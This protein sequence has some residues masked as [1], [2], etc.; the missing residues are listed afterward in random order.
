V[1]SAGASA[2]LVQVLIGEGKLDEAARRLADH[3]VDLSSDDYA[4]LRRK[5]VMG[6]INAGDLARADSALGADSTVDGL[7]LAGRLRLYHGDLAGAVRQLKAA[8]PFAGDRADAT[9]RT[10]LLALL[11]PIQADSLPEL[12]QALLA[13]AR[14]DT[15]RAIDGLEHVGAGLPPASGGAE[16]R[17]MGGRLAAASGKPAVAERLLAAAAAPEAPGT[18]PAAELALAELMLDLNRPQEAVAR[19][20]HLILSYPSS[21][22]VP[23]ARRRL[24]EA[25]GAVPKT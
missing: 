13:L 15:T 5:L 25:R 19:L 14:G 22:L 12:G 4:A 18:A 11:Q 6:Y 8:G 1:V 20:E 9:E 17:L 10:A 3:E 16:L 2:T 7:A 21:A 24:D 23:Q